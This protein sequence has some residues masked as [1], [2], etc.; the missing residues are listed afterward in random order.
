MADEVIVNVAAAAEESPAETV[1]EEI[2]AEEVEAE[3]NV[4]E[5]WA[6]NKGKH[7]KQRRNNRGTNRTH[8]L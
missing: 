8:Y 5:L 4:E 3:I 7:S 6:G 2:A 1:V